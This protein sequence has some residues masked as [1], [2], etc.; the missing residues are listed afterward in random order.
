MHRRSLLQRAAVTIPFLPGIWSWPLGRARAQGAGR[1]QSRVRPGDPA[2]PSEASW[3]RLSREVGG[4]LVKVQSPLAACLEAPSSPRCAQVFKELKNPYYLGDEVG[5]TQSLGWVDA[6]TSRP[7]AYAVAARDDGG[8]RR[9]RQFRPREQSAARREGRRPQL[10]G[11]LQRRR[12][13]ADL[14]AGDERGHPAR[15]VRRRRVRGTQRAAAG[16]H[17]RGGRDLGAGLRRR[18]DEGGPLRPGRRLPDRGRRGPDPERRLRQ[19]LEGL[20]HGR[21]EPAGGRDRH[22]RR[23]GEDRQRLHA[24]RTCSGASRAAAAAA[25][26]S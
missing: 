12:L 2:W 5:L 15:R 18:H 17:G 20:R 10:P 21:G 7:S 19:L 24:I 6:W 26:A 4:R 11:H 22:R 9:G 8:C 16:G 23:R 1:S 3:D 14:D 13:V 25:S